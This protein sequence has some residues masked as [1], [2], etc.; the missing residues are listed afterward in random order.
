MKKEKGTRDSMGHTQ[1]TPVPQSHGSG[2]ASG[3]GSTNM[4]THTTD[5]QTGP[6]P[7][8]QEGLEGMRQEINGLQDC[9]QLINGVYTCAPRPK[10]AHVYR[11]GTTSW[12]TSIPSED[13]C[14]EF[15]KKEHVQSALGHAVG[16]GSG[17]GT[18]TGTGTGTGDWLAAPAWRTLRGFC[19]RGL[20]EHGIWL[21]KSEWTRRDMS[22]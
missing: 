7:G 6:A 19:T 16:S 10:Y 1:S 20:R 4:S 22:G 14:I 13:F 9:T 3:L 12:P 5:Q 8:S 2:S 11:P 18:G 15:S 21:V 17:S